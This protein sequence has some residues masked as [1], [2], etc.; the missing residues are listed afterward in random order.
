M[1]RE[2]SAVV[3]LV[4]EVADRLLNGL[5]QSANVSVARGPDK[6]DIPAWEADARAL[7]VAARLRSTYVVVAAS[8]R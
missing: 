4:G 1:R 3:V 2:S 6:E 7:E 5:A 8:E